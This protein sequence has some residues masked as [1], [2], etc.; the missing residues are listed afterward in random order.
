MSIEN[1]TIDRAAQEMLRRT[2]ADGVEV[3][4]DRLEA[5]EPQCGFGTLGLCCRNC[6]QGP[7]RIN[8]F[9]KP[10]RGV[11]GADAHTIVARNLL[12]SLAG[13][14]AAHVDHAYDV[15]EALK[16]IAEGSAADYELKGEEK[17]KAVAAK[18][19][20]DTANKDKNTLAQ[21]VAARAYETFTSHSSEPMAWLKYWAPAERIET[22]TKLGVVP[23]NADREIRE[24]MHQTTMGMDADPV[25]LLLAGIKQGI[26]DGFAGLK[27]A[28][29]MQDIIFGTPQP[30]TTQTNLGVLKKEYINVVV[31]GHVPLLSEKIVQWCRE[32]EEDAKEAGAAGINVAGICCT[33]NEVLMRQGIPSATNFSGQELALAT[34]AVDLMVVDVQC[35]MP[36]LTN[37]AQCYHGEI[38]TTMPITK[39]PG[40]DHV[41]FSFEEADQQAEKI[42]R[43]AI[44]SFKRRDMA[45]V[46]IPDEKADI[47][48]GFSTEAIV[49]A[50]SKVDESDPLKPLVDAIKSGAILGAVGTV[51]CNNVK[52]TQD[53][54]HVEMVKKLVA[55]DVLVVATGCS[56]HALGKA[57]LLHPNATNE[58]AGEGLKAVLTVV[59]EAAGLGGPLPPVLHMGSCVD[60]SR[61]GD[62]LMA[63]A[64]YLGVNVKDLP[65]AASAPEPQ[66]E[67]A[68]SIGTWAVAMGIFTHLGLPP[69]VLGSDVVAGTLTGDKLESLIG[70]KFYVETDA[71][72][73]VEGIIEH[74]KA[75]RQAL[76]I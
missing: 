48:A 3:V 45:R 65:V 21:E 66:H 70:G 25:N 64:D 62:L 40:A 5:Q 8:P 16:K 60:N 1:K 46:K 30:V 61:I 13:G 42:V 37:I 44:A 54:M 50:L 38:V 18:I 14:A 28:T 41:P 32:L 52:I 6:L 17:L 49:G 35:I 24:A 68:L 19:G 7:C 34:G 76:G 55:N 43:K 9:G 75:K 29:D 33:G 20:L 73:A 63:L 27:L 67:K 47:I 22:W 74:I 69:Q 11:C 57:G 23:R 72:A 39:I 4:W 58:F 51:G 2:Q 31:H 71:K 53:L 12:R 26:V 56:A 15:L 36:S 59:G 10:D